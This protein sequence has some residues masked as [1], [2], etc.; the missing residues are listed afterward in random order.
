MKSPAAAATAPPRVPHVPSAQSRGPARGEDAPPTA[1]GT[2]A[3]E[4][5]LRRRLAEVEMRLRDIDDD[6]RRMQVHH[7]QELAT[8]EKENKSLLDRLEVLRMEECM[9]PEEARAIQ[10]HVHLA[11][12]VVA[13][14]APD[15]KGESRLLGATSAKYQQAKAVVEAKRK[16]C[17][18]AEQQLAEARQR[19]AELRRRRQTL[20]QEIFSTRASAGAKMAAGERYKVQVREQLRGLEEQV[21]R[22]QERFSGMVVEAKRTRTA[23]D[24]LLVS[25]TNNEKMYSRRY[26]ALLEKRREMAFL[27]EICN[28]LAEERQQVT[29][30]L[31]EVKAYLAEENRQ[32]EAAFQ[33][34]SAVA[35]ENAAA[36]TANREKSEELR[37]LTLQTRAEREALE[38]QNDETKAALERQR[39]RHVTR[40]LNDAAVGGPY[41]DTSNSGGGRDGGEPN[42]IRRLSDEDDAQSRNGDDVN[43]VETSFGSSS[44]SSGGSS[45]AADG[46]AQQIRE[47]E[48]YFRKLA[49][50]VQSDAIDDVVGFID[51]AA[52]ARYR[53]FDEMNALKRDIAELTAEKA[54][55]QAQLARSGTSFDAAHSNGAAA[56]VVTG[57]SSSNNNAN[58]ALTVAGEDAPPASPTSP[59]ACLAA[60]AEVTS[61]EELTAAAAAPAAPQTV[62][63]V[64]RLRDASS[65]KGAA[66]DTAAQAAEKRTERMRWLLAELDEVREAVGQQEQQREEST[67]VLS[68]VIAQVSDAFRGL[69]CSVAELRTMTGLEGVQRSTLLPCLSIVEQRVEEYLV[70][71]SR[72]QRDSSPWHARGSA[73]RTVL[74]RPDLPPKTRGECG[75]QVAPQQ[76]PRSTDVASMVPYI[77]VDAANTSTLEEL[78]DE[79]PLSDLE[80]REVVEKKRALLRC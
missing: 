17:A 24:A 1:G 59:T 50:V 11:Q 64:R 74:R 51:V 10:T 78:V 5:Q 77:R 45:T 66:A 42:F 32:Y 72:G 40:R 38:V 31:Q 75:A 58:D 63:P 70:A 21:E 15:H 33:E 8:L 12:G 18:Q 52:D 79:R 13:G 46:H 4:T 35:D 43:G 34:L 20:K 2:V 9:S 73:A 27:M 57:A 7:E 26:D 14:A 44:S 19:L 37:R 22:E 55:L 3:S 39:H 62:E 41:M 65:G 6:E 53:C 23:I 71:Y 28:S 54:V 49:D 80:L 48:D 36:Q 60:L 69:G 47:F 68:Q 30:E 25:Q 56:A 29:A 61:I 67:A 16:E 76:L